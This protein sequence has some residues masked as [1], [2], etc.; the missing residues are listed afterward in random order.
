MGLQ[1]RSFLVSVL[2]Q[3]SGPA[4]VLLFAVVEVFAQM[5]LCFVADVVEVFVVD[6]EVGEVAGGGVF[7]EWHGDVAKGAAAG[8]LSVDAVEVRVVVTG[9][10][11]ESV[12]PMRALHCAQRRSPRR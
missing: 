12:R 10:S 11:S 2:L 5:C 4:L 1:E 9:A 3:L 7:N 6:V 8:L